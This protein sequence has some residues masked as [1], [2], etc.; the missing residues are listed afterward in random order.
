VKKDFQCDSKDKR[1][2]LL[3]LLAC[4]PSV[5][6]LKLNVHHAT[7]A[8]LLGARLPK[9]YRSQLLSTQVQSMAEKVVD[10]EVAV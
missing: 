3:Q 1:F 4:L 8:H 2:Y 7:K 5:L 10:V 9:M 6:K